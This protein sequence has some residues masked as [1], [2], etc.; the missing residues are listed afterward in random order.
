MHITIFWLIIANYFGI[1]AIFHFRQAKINYPK[2]DPSVDI[3]TV[4]GSFMNATAQTN[5]AKLDKFFN[6]FDKY[7]ENNNSNNKMTNMIAGGTYIVSSIV[8]FFSAYLSL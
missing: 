2:F 1:F 4:D 3:E 5:E 8:S 7:V 6:E